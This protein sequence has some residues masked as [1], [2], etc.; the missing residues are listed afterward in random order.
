LIYESQECKEPTNKVGYKILNTLICYTHN[1]KE[2][3]I[4]GILAQSMSLLH[5]EDKY[6]NFHT[7]ENGIESLGSPLGI[8]VMLAPKLHC[9]FEGK[10]MERTRKVALRARAYSCTYYQ[11]PFIG[12]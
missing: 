6:Y 10:G 11:Q 9:E 2:N 5:A 1:A 4:I 7:Q 3:P 12:R 8:K